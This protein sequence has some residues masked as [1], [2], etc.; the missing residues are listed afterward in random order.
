MPGVDLSGS[1][2]L[3][4]QVNH[5]WGRLITGVVF[6]SLLGASAQIA[7]GRTYNSFDPSFGDL[8]TQGV[9]QNMNQ[10]GQQ[11]TRRNLNIQPTLEIRP[12][13]RFNVFVHRDLGLESYAG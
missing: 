13:F 1:A 10:V 8:A 12:G 3:T 7:Q 4:D 11:I 5:H 9:A 2:G 6:S